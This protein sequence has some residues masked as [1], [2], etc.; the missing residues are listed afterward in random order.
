MFDMV[1]SDG[2]R[3]TA[4]YARQRIRW[5]P[6]IEVTQTKG[7]SEVHPQFSLNDEFAAFEVR[8][9]LLTNAESKVIPNS[10]ARSA[11]LQGLELEAETGVNP[12]KFGMI[13]STDSHNGLATTEE[14]NFYGKL[15]NHMLT[16]VRR[17][18]QS[19]FPAWEISASGLA[20]VW[21]T[22]NTRSSILKAFQRKEVYATTGSRIA[23]RMFGG[24]NFKAGDARARDIAGVGYRRG[25]PMGGDLNAAPR[26]KAPGFLLHAA[27]DPLGA[28]LDRIQIVKGWLDAEGRKQERVHGDFHLPVKLP[29][30]DGV[31]LV[32]QA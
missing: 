14:S 16:E 3:I 31:Y 26:G 7:T 11:L 17:G 2:R 4:E 23:L 15:A 20:G 25:V 6:V 32:L 19:N 13:G 18:E 24:F 12:Y 8:N 21:A 28:N 29:S 1:D 10:Y 30:A 27:K 5:E 22:E 9:K